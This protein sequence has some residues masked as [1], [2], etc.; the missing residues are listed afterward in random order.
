MTFN[1]LA[2][3]ETVAKTITNLKNNG[4]NPELAGNGQQA[5]DRVLEILPAGAEVFTMQSMTL[6]S[7]E[8]DTAINESGKYNSVRNQLSQMDRKTQS[9]EMQKLGATPQYSVGSVHAVTE[10]GKVVIASNTGSQLGAY[11]YGSAHVI[12]VVGTQKIVP[13]LD[14]AFKRIYDYILPLE[15]DRLNKAYNLTAGSYV[16]KILIINREINPSRLT[17]VFV[18]EVIGF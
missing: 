14:S 16:S 9:L 10:D 8:I 13:D 6:K 5:K 17:L 1:E 11:V 4:I 12:W 3:S 7:L 18:P 15:S 2:N